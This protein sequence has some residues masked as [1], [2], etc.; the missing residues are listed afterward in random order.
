MRHIQEPPAEPP[1]ELPDRPGTVT[2]RVVTR[3][4]A[5]AAPAVLTAVAAPAYAGSGTPC[6]DSGAFL[7]NQGFGFLCPWFV[8]GPGSQPQVDVDISAVSAQG[9][10]VTQGYD[11]DALIR[12]KN[13][14]SGNANAYY[15]RLRQSLSMKP[16]D[17]LT[18]ALTFTRSLRNFALTISNIDRYP[19]QWSDAVSVSS[20]ASVLTR[21]SNV[22]GSGTAADPFVA[23]TAN[24]KAVEGAD[25]NVA[26]RVRVVWP[27][28]LTRVSV[29]YVAA[30]AKSASTTGPYIG[31]GTF[32]YNNCA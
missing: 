21:G 13:D 6:T 30:D 23:N 16:G 4:A 18:M 8:L 24:A 3:T 1:A 14:P 26:S 17:T 9:Q 5:W 22:I 31:V 28:S 19:G 11:T 12:I 20:G 10:P 25:N 15:I 32:S 29:T 7:P 27:G 2:R